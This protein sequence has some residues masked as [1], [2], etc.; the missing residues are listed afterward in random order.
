METLF[1]VFQNKLPCKFRYIPNP[2][3]EHIIIKQRK[4]EMM[5]KYCKVLPFI[6]TFKNNFLKHLMK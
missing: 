2:I 6:I 3:R 5:I 4:I 1:Y